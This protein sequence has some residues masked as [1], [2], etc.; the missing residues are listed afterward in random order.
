MRCNVV[1]VAMYKLVAGTWS[2][3]CFFELL[4]YTQLAPNHCDRRLYLYD[5]GVLVFL[6]ASMVQMMVYF[7][8]DRYASVE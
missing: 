2:Y 3:F 7:C 8:I 5:M 4:D 6:S 1:V